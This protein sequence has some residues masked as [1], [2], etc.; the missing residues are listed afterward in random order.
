L[1]KGASQLAQWLTPLPKS[2]SLARRSQLLEARTGGD[3]H[4]VC[5][6][7]AAV[8]EAPAPCAVAIFEVYEIRH[9]ED[10][11][12]GRRLLLRDGAEI[13]AGNA[14]GKARITVNL[15]DAEQLSAEGCARQ[16]H[17]TAAHAYR[18][19]RCGQPGNATSGDQ[20]VAIDHSIS[21]S[22]VMDQSLYQAVRS[23]F[24]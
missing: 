18:C 24:P 21:S 1:S 4:C 20:D 16:D 11:A 15:V 9:L 3:D 8:A 7:R 23:E 10:R 6:D 17:G 19:Q 12:R 2:C 22:A 13:V 5:L 14:V